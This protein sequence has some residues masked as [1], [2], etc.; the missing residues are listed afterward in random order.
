MGLGSH[1]RGCEAA[2]RRRAEH[3]GAP[4]EETE[5][6]SHQRDPVADAVVDE[7]DENAAA[8]FEA[9]HEARLPERYGNKVREQRQWVG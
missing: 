3:G 6:R 1:L 8:V 5:Q 2:R 4:V 9:R 7:E